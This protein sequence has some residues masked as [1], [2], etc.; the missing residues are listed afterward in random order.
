M[1]KVDFGTVTAFVDEGRI[2]VFFPRGYDGLKNALKDMKGRWNPE[3]KCWSLEPRY[4]RMGPDE[5]VGRIGDVLLRNAPDRWEDAVRRFGGFACASRKYE[6][7]VGLGG[8]RIRIPEGH[9]SHYVLKQVEGGQQEGK[10]TWLI[11]SM[12]ASSPTIGA[13]LERVVGEDED[14]FVS[15]VEHLETRTIR[16]IVPVSPEE[17]DGLGLVANRFVYADHAFLKVADPQV[18]NGPIHAWPFKVL[19]REDVDGGAEVRLSYL[20]PETAYKAVRYRQAQ[21]EE[22]RTPL[23]DLTHATGKWT[24][25][26]L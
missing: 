26:R 23:L 21:P 20:P 5:I 11:P 16:G 25:K 19:S 1:P 4:A 7:K 12:S 14:I 3:R 18:K 2:D 17:A 15:Y 8:I 9:P 13:V 24:Y 6:V 22:A 10:E